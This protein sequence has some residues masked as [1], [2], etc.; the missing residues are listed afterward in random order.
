MKIKILYLSHTRPDIAYVVS[1]VSQ[2]MHSPSEEHMEVVYQ[3]IRYL[4]CVL[5]K[6]L[7]FSENDVSNIEGYIDSN[8]AGDQAT[9]KSTSCYFMF[10][11]GN[12]VTWRSK[13][14]K[15]VAKSSTK[16]EFRGMAQ[17]LCKMLWINNVLKDLG[18]DYAKPMKLYYDNKAA[19]EIAQN[20]V[21]HD[22]TKHVEVDRHFVKEKL[23]KKKI[24]QFPFVQSESQVVDM[25]TK[26]RRVFHDTI[27]KLGM[28]VIVT[29][30][31][32]P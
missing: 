28:I 23:D 12:L 1:V 25:L 32:T 16:A 10:I 18:M 11:E 4:K 20:P 9:R 3:I 24:I 30:R 22:C 26:E 7:L 31:N 6:G 14:Q 2:F 27:D 21:Q 8:W 17:G 15:D 13:K 19:I 5:G 29:P